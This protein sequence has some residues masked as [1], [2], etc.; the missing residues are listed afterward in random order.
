MTVTVLKMTAF[1][2]EFMFTYYSLNNDNCSVVGFP[3]DCL[4]CHLSSLWYICACTVYPHVKYRFFRNT[5]PEKEIWANNSKDIN[6][7]YSSYL[8]EQF[9]CKRASSATYSWVMLC[10]VTLNSY[11]RCRLMSHFKYM[12]DCTDRQTETDRQTYRDRQR[13]WTDHSVQCSVVLRLPHYC[14]PSYVSQNQ[15]TLRRHTL[16]YC[17]PRI[18][19]NIF[20][21]RTHS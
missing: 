4:A 10:T 15:L 7:T 18:M 11:R 19:T 3:Y 12:A 5:T 9:L 1:I 17:V 20:A 21:R 8:C 16:R 14:L 6:V 2:I 13:Y